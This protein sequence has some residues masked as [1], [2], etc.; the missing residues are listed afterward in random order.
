MQKLNRIER[1][2]LQMSPA[3][4]RD[5]LE[6]IDWFHPDE[7]ERFYL[8]NFGLYNIKLD[9]EKW[10][11]RL[12]IDGGRI[13]PDKLGI[14]AET[15]IGHGLRI[16]LT[17]RS[18]IELHDIHPQSVLEI[19]KELHENDICSMQTLT[20]N[21][22]AV[23]TDPLD[24]VSP[25][26]LVETYPV[27]MDIVE[28]FRD[29][30]DWTGT[31]PRKF[32]TAIVGCV[33]PSFNPWGNDLLFALARSGDEMGFNV[34]LGGKNGE[35]A[36]NA[37]IFCAPDDV[38]A[39]FEAVAT[40]YRTMGLRGSRAKTR[41]R[42]TIEEFGMERIMEAL[43]KEYGSEL[44]GAGEL[45]M[46]RSS[47]IRE[48]SVSIERFGRYGEIDPRT[49]LEIASTALSEDLRIRLT[50][51]QEIWL[52]DPH[53]T[54]KDQKVHLSPVTAC[55]GSRY[56]PLSLWDIKKDVD[57]LPMER[58]SRLGLSVGFSGC[59]KG[60]G[61]HTH[62]DIGLVGLRSNL[63]APTE[64][65]CRIF[66]GALQSPEVAPAMMLYYSVPERALGRLLDVILDDYEASGKSAFDLFRL[67]VLGRYDIEFLRLWFLVRQLYDLPEKIYRRFFKNDDDSCFFFEN[68]L[69]E[70][71]SA[72]DGFPI[73]K[74]MYLIN[75][76]LSHRLWDLQVRTY[77]SRPWRRQSP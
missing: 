67:D 32:N 15:A 43:R 72:V 35:V 21:F 12:R 3:R 18:Q 5:D 74:E 77:I 45:L 62:S 54:V 59:L 56:C 2:K 23:V 37:D 60:C 75:T 30:D 57:T 22:R 50:P 28:R 26:C 58:I 13:E 64:R 49:L 70:Y 38:P 46:R 19:W 24:G 7:R 27:V 39:L 66:I 47:Y 73:E 51:T 4:F 48:A 36:M 41:L 10:M 52:I 53:R 68:E 33:R 8:K 6:E 29:R 14:I 17:S 69:M 71:L 16:L 20:D 44:R 1:F 76:K 63:Y 42:H 25:E 11:I 9:P 61:R 40:I 31:I 34:Y 65:A 55:A